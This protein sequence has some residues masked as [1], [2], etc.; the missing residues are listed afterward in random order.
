MHYSYRILFN[1]VT[2]GILFPNYM[3]KQIPKYSVR[4][5]IYQYI[6]VNDIRG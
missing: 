2:F 3:K 1:D 6:H 4:I 5:F